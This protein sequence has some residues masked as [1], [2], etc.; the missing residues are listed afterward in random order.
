MNAPFILLI[1]PW[2]Y[3]FAA[4]DLWSRPL[5][6]LYLGGWLKEAGA[7]VKLLD[8]LDRG[9]PHSGAPRGPASVPAGR[10]PYRREVRPTPP[11]L[12]DVPRRF[13]RYGWP[14]PVFLAKLKR[15]AKP[16]AVLVHAI[17]TYWYP[18]A[19]RAVELV[20]REWPDTPVLMGGV[21][22]SLCPGHAAA[23]PGGALAVPGPVEKVPSEF[24]ARNLSPALAGLLTRAFYRRNPLS[25][26]PAWDLYQN[27]SV[28]VILSGRGCPRRCPYCASRELFRETMFRSSEDVLD[29]I[30]EALSDYG[31]E[32]LVFYDDAVSEGPE[33]RFEELLKGLIGLKRRFPG[34]KVHLPNGLFVAAVNRE[35]A[36]LM[37]AAGFS[38]IR[39]GVETTDPGRQR[40]LGGKVAPGQ[41]ARAAGCLTGAGFTPKELGAYILTGLPGPYDYQ[42]VFQSAQKCWSLGLKPHLAEYAPSPGT[43]LWPQAVAQSPLPLAAEPLCHNNSAHPLRPAGFSF[44]TYWAL[45][46]AVAALA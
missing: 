17:M 8:C 34:L 46:R 40:A 27:N 18:G 7:E 36:Q 31:T 10:G 5:G 32:E 14:E 43:D 21:Y 33:G 41:L 45:K 1:N 9:D 42:S 28:R 2:I 19:Y 6:L 3:D 12:S 37:K 38:T 16:E 4:Y 22:A 29:E 24:W 25:G 15:L 23:N 11:P 44:Q 20:R 13:A 35:R 39:L 26:R 30:L